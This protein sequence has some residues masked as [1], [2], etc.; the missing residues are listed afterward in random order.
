MAL[1]DPQSITIS[2]STISLPR[3]STGQGS[4]T[5]QSADGLTAL[6]LST[7][8]S[9]NRNNTRLRQVVRVDRSK[10]APDVFIPTQNVEKSMSLYMVFDRP[11]VGYDNTEAEAVFVGFNSLITASTNTV[12]KKLLGGES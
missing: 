12:V 5:Y 9:S 4:S 3:V 1:T 2:G 6:Q 10:I 8:R 7:S 11:V